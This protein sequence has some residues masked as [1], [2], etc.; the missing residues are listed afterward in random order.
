MLIIILKNR[1]ARLYGYTF[2]LLHVFAWAA[3]FKY[4]CD[5]FVI[6]C[7]MCSKNEIKQMTDSEYIVVNRLKWSMSPRP[8]WLTTA[9]YEPQ[10][11]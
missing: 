3:T 9:H 6:T 11:N 7:F 1:P 4:V 8:N 2:G 10:L 5:Y